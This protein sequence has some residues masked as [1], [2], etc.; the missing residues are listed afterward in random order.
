VVRT[1][2]SGST[3]RRRHASRND[4]AW[5]FAGFYRGLG[6]FL[7]VLVGAGEQHDLMA[8]RPQVAGHNIRVDAGV[9]MAHMGPV[10]HVVNRRG[11]VSVRHC[12]S[13][14]EKGR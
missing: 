2:R 13:K 11:D 9:G 1:N 3:D 4:F 5:R 8:G 10:V 7:A 12:R 14:K 6:D